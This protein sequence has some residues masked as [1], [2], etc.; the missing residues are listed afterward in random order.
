MYNAMKARDARTKAQQVQNYDEGLRLED[1]IEKEQN[2]AGRL[3]AQIRR[4]G[5]R[6][7]RYRLWVFYHMRLDKYLT[8][9]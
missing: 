4:N 2:Y 8:R 9:L 1:Y 7:P 3:R 6:G 5:Y